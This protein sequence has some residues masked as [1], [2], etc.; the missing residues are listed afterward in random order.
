[1]R[2]DTGAV[3]RAPLAGSDPAR[4][5]EISAFDMGTNN[6]FADILFMDDTRL[7]VVRLALLAAKT[8]GVRVVA[9]D[10]LRQPAAVHARC[11][12]ARFAPRPARFL[13]SRRSLRS[14]S[15][16]QSISMTASLCQ[17][18]PCSAVRGRSCGRM[19]G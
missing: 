8:T 15:L 16:A 4:A 2:L 11:S 3:V 6:G 9:D 12:H 5:R 14:P 17:S 19:M 10:Q 13:C 18:P 1:V 7:R